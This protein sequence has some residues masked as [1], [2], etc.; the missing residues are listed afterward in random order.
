MDT[1][2]QERQEKIASMPRDN[3]A[4]TEPP[5]PPPDTLAPMSSLTLPPKYDVAVLD[6]SHP[7]FGTDGFAWPVMICWAK[8]LVLVF[9]QSKEVHRLLKSFANE[10]DDIVVKTKEQLK[11]EATEA[12]RATFVYR[13]SRCAYVGLMRV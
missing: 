6:A 10:R 12:W 13:F 7:L 9:P 4:V 3:A 5:P 2:E 1:I 11:E 8:K